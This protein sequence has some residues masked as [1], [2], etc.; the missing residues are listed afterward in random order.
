MRRDLPE[1]S[2]T[3]TR[4]IE[5]R[6]GRTPREQAINF[7]GRPFSADSFAGFWRYWNPVWSYYLTYFCYRHLR[8]GMPR[9]LAAWLTFLVCGVVH[10]LPFVAGAYL[11]GG[12]GV[13]F[14]LT[15]FFALTGGLVWLTEHWRIRL[16]G[17][18]M[19]GRWVAHS[20]A[21]ATCYKA[22]LFLTSAH[23]Q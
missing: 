20:V 4:Y 2:M 16:D 19:V 14:T 18:P 1:T 13:S 17:A 9:P 5:Q 12:R 7:L 23:S 6:L 3:L 21:L 22:A 10:D 8:R 11:M 15:V